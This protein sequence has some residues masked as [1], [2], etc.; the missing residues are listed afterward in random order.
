VALPSQENEG[1]GMASSSMGPS[2]LQ[3]LQ[4]SSTKAKP[5]TLVFAHFRFARSFWMLG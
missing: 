4:W 2:S 3:L 1:H 5:A